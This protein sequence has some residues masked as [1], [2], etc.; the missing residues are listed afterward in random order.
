MMS[1]CQVPLR[2]SLR[3]ESSA[4]ISSLMGVSEGHARKLTNQ[5]LE[6]FSKIHEDSV[7]KLYRN[8]N[9]YILQIDETTDLGFSMIVA[10][11][12]SVS[13]CIICEEMRF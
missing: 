6:I 10:V 9:P 3:G 1:W 13:G 11:K 5:A 8:M 12:D 4:E 2:D 7:S